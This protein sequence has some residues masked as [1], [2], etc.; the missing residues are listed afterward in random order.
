MVHVVT[1]ATSPRPRIKPLFVALAAL[2][3][4]GGLTACQD[5]A[6]IKA[7]PATASAS[8]AVPAGLESFYTQKVSWYACDKKGMGEAKSGKDTGFTCA[9]VKVPLDYDNPGGETIEIAVKK[10]T[11]SG[12]SVGSLFVN[13]GGP[14]G[15][16]I[17]LVESAGSYFSKNLTSSYDVVGFDPRGVGSSTAI[18]CGQAGPAGGAGAG[19]PQPGQSFED[20]AQGYSAGVT[21][22][23]QQCAEHSEPGLLDHVGTLSSARD[24]DV[25]RAVMGEESLN[26]LGY[27]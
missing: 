21:A 10:R 3:A 6:E 7:T 13:P 24:L 19:Q 11:A 17:E 26:Y 18:D 25:L 9:K 27:S 15:S 12:D 16:G 23:E 4:C 5:E 1:T 2:L 22:L 20:W 8:A 14:G